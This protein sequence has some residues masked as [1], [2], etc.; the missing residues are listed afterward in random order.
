MDTIGDKPTAFSETRAHASE[1]V[2][3]QQK[4]QLSQWKVSAWGLQNI[5]FLLSGSHDS[6]RLSINDGI[7]IEPRAVI[8]G[9]DRERCL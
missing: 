6:D 5:L 8:S 9:R 4:D 2:S 3:N 7:H 1:L